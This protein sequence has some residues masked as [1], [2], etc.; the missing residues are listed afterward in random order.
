MKKNRVIAFI[1]IIFLISLVLLVPVMSYYIPR[2]H[3]PLSN[4]NSNIIVDPEIYKMG[5]KRVLSV[6]WFRDYETLERGISILADSGV[7]IVHRYNMFP[8]LLVRISKDSLPLIVSIRGVTGVYYNKHYKLLR[9]KPIG[10]LHPTTLQSSKAIGADTFWIRGYKGDQIR[11]GI[12]DTGID[13][14]HPDFQGKIVA[15][16]SFVLRKYGYKNDDPDPSDGAIDI[17]HGTRVAGIA[18]GAGKGDPELGTGVAPNALIISAKVFPSGKETTATLAGILAAIEWCVEQGADVI[19]MSLGGGADY[20][21]PLQ[22]VIKEAAELGVTVVIA[23]GNEGDNGFNTMSVGSPGFSPYAITVGATDIEGE[24]IKTLYSSIGPTILL[25]V[26]PDICAPSGVAAPISTASGAV[27]PYGEAEEGTSFSAPHIA[28]A[29]ALIAQY[30]KT[31]GIEKKYWPGIIKYVLMKSA[32]PI[33]SAGI[34][35]YELWAGAGFVNLTAA[36]DLLE[37]MFS[38]TTTIP[39][40]IFVTP[41]RIPTGATNKA[42]FFPYGSKVFQGMRLEFNFTIVSMRDVTVNVQL[43]G[44]ISDVI[45]LFSPTTFSALTP[46]TLWEFNV[47]F[48]T[49]AEGYYSG[50]IIFSTASDTFNVSMEFHLVKPKMWW[51]FDL[52]HTSW[53]IDFKYG[54]YK[55]LYKLLENNNVSVEQWYFGSRPLTY[56]LLSKYDFVFIPDAASYYGI[57]NSTAHSVGISSV[58]FSGEEIDAIVKYVEAGGNIIL[59][60]MTPESNNITEL[61]RLAERFGVL[62]TKKFLT[63]TQEPDIATVSNHVLFRGVSGL[64]FYGVALNPKDPGM[65][66][67]SYKGYSVAALYASRRGGFALILA[68]NFVFDNWALR[69]VYRVPAKEVQQFILNILELPTLQKEILVKTLPDSITRGETIT[70]EVTTNLTN[71]EGHVTDYISTTPLV[72]TETDGKLI[73][74]YAT[75]LAGDTIVYIKASFKDDYWIHIADVVSVAKTE[76]NPPTVSVSYAN[77]STIFY[78]GENLTLRVIIEDDSGLIYHKKLVSI[79]ANASEYTIKLI[80]SK[81]TKLVLEVII[82]QELI[83]ELMSKHESFLL[84]LKIDAKDVNLNQFIARYVFNIS[85]KSPTSIVMLLG[86]GI[87]VAVVIAILV[88]LIY[89]KKTV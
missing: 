55:N 39:E 47:T 53:T 86:I 37:S 44:N 58:R 88:L 5:E 30:L 4:K 38:E 15:M 60:G 77:A 87:T 13:P 46:T 28:G 12:I 71:V 80:E 36:Y 26:K 18:A 34:K 23:A 64:P 21:D 73:A 24:K 1:P 6:I 25:A 67:A 68:T 2:I 43:V 61:N 17:W 51:L 35:Y 8:A 84:E 31:R 52:R 11:I 48:S 50:W 10:G 16:K 59:I 69:G 22:R 45:T 62:F 7:E 74:S 57:Y 29:A 54:Q 9:T 27:P 78:E 42:L 56:E 76:E 41:I 89:R 32:S 49:A 81:E 79:V 75:K 63:I 19:N 70:I 83:S 72:F 33:V 82:P 14:D 3:P 66:I 85:K 65:S 40:N 20:Y